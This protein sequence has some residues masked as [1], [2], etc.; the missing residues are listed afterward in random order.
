VVVKDD[1]STTVSTG[2]DGFDMV[3][4]ITATYNKW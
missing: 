1:I 3:L 4:Y 2:F